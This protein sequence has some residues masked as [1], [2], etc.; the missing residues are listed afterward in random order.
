MDLKDKYI[1]MCKTDANLSAVASKVI[2]GNGN[3]SVHGASSQSHQTHAGSIASAI[4]QEGDGS[5]N[6]SNSPGLVAQVDDKLLPFSLKS[7]DGLID[8]EDDDAMFISI[9]SCHDEGMHIGSFSNINVKG[10]EGVSS[11]PLPFPSIP[12]G[13]QF[14]DQITLLE[15]SELFNSI[16]DH[17]IDDSSI[18]MADV[19]RRQ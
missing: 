1:N 9:P 10:Y 14:M 8:V 11:L 7:S 4:L 17:N 15:A 19:F 18:Q 12:T 5:S 16:D 6:S 3:V 13:D 2:G